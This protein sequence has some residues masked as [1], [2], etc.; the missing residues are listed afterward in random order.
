MSGRPHYFLPDLFSFRRDRKPRGGEAGE[1][2]RRGVVHVE[3]SGI[4][5]GGEECIRERGIAPGPSGGGMRG[6]KNKF[7]IVIAF[8]LPT[9]RRVRPD[10]KM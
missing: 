7:I 5:G 6:N 9:Q 8:A 4:V 3:K 1:G 10:I 2:W